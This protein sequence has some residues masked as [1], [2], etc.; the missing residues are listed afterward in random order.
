MLR[1]ICNALFHKFYRHSDF[2]LEK[3][4]KTSWALKMKQKAEKKSVKDFEKQLKAEKTQK[5]Q[6]RLTG[7]HL[8]DIDWHLSHGRIQRGAEGPDTPPPLKNPKNIGFLSNTG[9]DLL[10]N[11]KATKPQVSYRFLT[12]E[13]LRLVLSRGSFL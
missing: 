13:N 2:R 4:L 7:P 3:T 1:L 12:A 11:H 9:L 6:V 8:D 10:K 5:L